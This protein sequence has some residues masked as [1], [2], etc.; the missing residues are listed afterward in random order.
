MLCMAES[1]FIS[2]ETITALLIS[3]VPNMEAHG[4]VMKNP[5]SWGLSSSLGQNAPG[6]ITAHSGNC[7]PTGNLLE[8]EEP[9]DYSPC[10]CKGKT[11]LKAL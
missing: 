11:Q 3:Y 6:E 7:L 10:G 1:L 4:T 5:S 8:P 9:G 2:S